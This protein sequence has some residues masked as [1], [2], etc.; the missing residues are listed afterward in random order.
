MSRFGEDRWDLSPALFFPHCDRATIGFT[1]VPRAFVPVVKQVIWL[2]LNYDGDGLA[3]AGPRPAVMTVWSQARYLVAFVDWVAAHGRDRLGQ[4]EGRDIDDY[5]EH[6]HAA[7]VS[8]GV[9]EDLLAAVV[10]LW[11]Y[12]PLLDPADRLPPAPP[13]N[14]ER[15]HRLL[16]GP[17][18][19]EL[20]TPRI[21]PAT[22]TALLSWA[23]RFVE[24]LADDII[25]AHHLA[26]RLAER[27][28]AHR[29]P[30][31]Y[32]RHRPAADLPA[33]LRG[34]VRAFSRM[35]IALPARPR[36]TDP[37]TLTYDLAYLGKL[38]G[39]RAER[40]DR[41][42]CLA[43]LADSGMP[44]RSGR[45]LPL[46]PTATIEGQLWRTAPIEDTEAPVLAR[47]LMT[48]CFIVVAYLSGMR[49]G[50][51]LALER[52]CLHRD[53]VTGM[54]TVRAR[55][56][57][58]VRDESG[59]AVPQ[60]QIRPDPWVVVEPVATAIA[61]ASRLHTQ[62]LLFPNRFITAHPSAPSRRYRDG[63]A[64]S[65][66]SMSRDL[67]AFLAWV[68]TH[69]EAVG[70]TDSIPPDLDH[71]S[72]FPRRLRRTLAWFIVRK[73]RGAVAAAIQYGH[74]NVAMTL[75][76]AG[77]YASGFPD[78]LAFE[79]W[80]ARLDLLTESHEHLTAGEHVS[81]PAAAE[82]RHRVQAGQRFA[83]HV[84]KTSRDAR[85]LLAN[86]DL[87]IHQGDGLTC[88]FDPHRA[89]CRAPGDPADMR[90]TPDL[91]DCR[92]NCANIARTDRD[93]AVVIELA[94]SLTG[95]AEDPLAPA[96]RRAR[97]RHELDRLHTIL[98]AHDD[99]DTPDA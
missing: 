42:D 27:G 36:A 56:W 48:A 41:P 87:Q 61:V 57:K 26:H 63:A 95:M 32:Y 65:A 28:R 72:I 12:H 8:R 33:E 21:P 34:L 29:R 23:L 44:L 90:C 98:A 67:D 22:M 88:V 25:D 97:L 24:D 47:H 37:T 45:P 52:G 31:T 85:N 78:D 86:P 15:T 2:M 14:G 84:L 1:A 80:L 69:C 55:H 68:N 9:K 18:T 10:R 11:T 30:D 92:P 43:V 77:T 13:W 62:P 17:R 76:Y 64:R 58:G 94:A 73:P 19:S 96:P 39:V 93:I 82:Y 3:S 5:L 38:L 51:A 4:L 89:A 59:A 53:P 7:E 49:P 50:E 83:G 16:G 71:P 79:Q 54:L 35:G 99:K 60:G 20:T 40:L 74:L 81:G 75:G 66:A 70:R 91:T 46:A 6:V